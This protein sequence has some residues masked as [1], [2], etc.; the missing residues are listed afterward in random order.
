MIYKKK[1]L[2]IRN[3]NNKLLKRASSNLT[4]WPNRKTLT[5][6]RMWSSLVGIVSH[7]NVI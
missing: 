7:P 4:Y 1:H 5:M 6:H 3:V 2:Q